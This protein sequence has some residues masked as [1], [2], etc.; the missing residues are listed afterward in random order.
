MQIIQQL[1]AAVAR[2]H[3]TEREA[4]PR[5]AT[6]LSGRDVSH[7]ETETDTTARA[8]RAA[9]WLALVEA[10]RAGWPDVIDALCPL[11]QRADERLRASEYLTWHQQLE[12]EGP[13]QPVDD[14]GGPRFGALG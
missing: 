12:A 9:L 1:P 3:A 13:H 2:L 7:R 11:L 6:E 14:V 5:R 8:V 4:R 10:Q